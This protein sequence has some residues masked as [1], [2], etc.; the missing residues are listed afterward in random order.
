MNC[1]SDS[2]RKPL[3]FNE[4]TPWYVLVVKTKGIK[5]GR[6]IQ[7]SFSCK[8]RARREKNRIK[9]C[10]EL[11]GRIGRGTV[12]NRFLYL[13]ERDFFSPEKNLNLSPCVILFRCLNNFHKVFNELKQE[14]SRITVP[15]L[16]LSDDFKICFNKLY[17]ASE[18]KM[19]EL[20][21]YCRIVKLYVKLYQKFA[22]TDVTELHLFLIDRCRTIRAT[23]AQILAILLE[24]MKIIG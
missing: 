24:K 12:G 7:Q 20:E 13:L 4:Y 21:S 5:T 2:P 18:K 8:D 16:T 11:K 15:H 6:F 22:Q 1:N 3:V 10:Y 9:E 17:S 19:T 14:S 23:E